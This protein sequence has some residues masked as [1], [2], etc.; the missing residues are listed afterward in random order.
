MTS[1]QF[2]QFKPN[3]MCSICHKWLGTC[4]FFTKGDHDTAGVSVITTA[5]SD[6]VVRSFKSLSGTSSIQ[7][8]TGLPA[9]VGE[10]IPIIVYFFSERWVA[11]WDKITVAF[12]VLFED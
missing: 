5:L 2:L 3:Y 6:W 10:A 12:T 11:W 8:F 7:V 9:V 1:H 4:L